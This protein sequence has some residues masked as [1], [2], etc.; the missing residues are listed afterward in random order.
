MD[1]TARTALA[2]YFT[3]SKGVLDQDWQQIRPRATLK[4]A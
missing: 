2:L 3:R 4:A 1:K